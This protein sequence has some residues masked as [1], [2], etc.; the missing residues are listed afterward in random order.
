MRGGPR[1][2][3]ATDPGAAH[4]RGASPPPAAAS[5]R[6]DAM[7]FLPDPLLQA[8]AAGA[9]V[10]TPNNRLARALTAGFD[11]AQ[12]K[13]GRS[14]WPA[15]RVL[16]WGA[17]LTALWQDAIEA[18]AINDAW[19]LLNAAQS[20]YLWRRIVAAQGGELIDVAGAARI[21][22]QAWSLAHEWGAGGESWRGW[23]NR[24][25][26]ADDDTAAF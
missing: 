23:A 14:A 3:R 7:P 25:A 26:P 9:T 4:S 15:A 10:V 19:R 11:A 8:L 17:W 21:A 24:L 22:A 12:R 6:L 16:P 1:K 13:S 20:N 2:W 5:H 18:E